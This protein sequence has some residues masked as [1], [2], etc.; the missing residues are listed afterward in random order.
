MKEIRLNSLHLENFMGIR[1]LEFSPM[2]KNAILRGDNGTFKTSTYSAFLWILFG[3]DSHGNATESFTIKTKKDG[4]VIHNIDHTVEAELLVDGVPLKLKRNYR[5]VWSKKRKVLKSHKTDYW[6]NDE[7]DVLKKDYDKRIAEIIPEETFRLLTDINYFNSDKFGWQKRRK[8]LF[9]LCEGLTE[10]ALEDAEK[11]KKILASKKKTINEKKDGIQ[12]RIDEK[13]RDLAAIADYNKAEIKA[14]ITDFEGQIQTIKSDSSR[15]ALLK[16]Q[17]EL[18]AKLSQIR[19][20]Q[21]KEKQKATKGIRVRIEKMEDDYSQAWRDL[22]G[23]EHELVDLLGITKNA[24]KKIESLYSEQDKLA[25]EKPDILDLCPTCSKPFLPEEKEAVQAEFNLQQSKKNEDIVTTG[26]K[27]RS[28]L[29]AATEEKIN[30]EV[31]LKAE[32]T[33]LAKIEKDLEKKKAEL[34]D[35]ISPPEISIGNTEI[36]TIGARLSEIDRKLEQKDQK[37]D[38]AT[39]EAELKTERTKIAKIDAGEDAKARIVELGE[40][41]KSLSAEIEK[42]EAD[43][44][45]AEEN[46][47]EQARLL[48]VPINAKFG[49]VKF[50]LFEKQMNEGVRPTCVTLIDGIPYGHGLNKGNEINAG[51]DIIHTLSQHYQIQCP[52]FIDN[53]ESISYPID[54][55]CQ[56]FKLIKVKDMK[57]LEITIEE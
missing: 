35:T 47:R 27:A 40:Q 56:C 23:T 31:K 54:P 41:E 49:L 15:F 9:Q 11:K 18:G 51:L 55:G 22:N 17:G 42:L 32:Q 6:I 20:G 2:G 21:E 13:E 19:A 14:R 45:K 7:P 43:L 34:E 44:F 39:L 57:K 38:R 3:K 5:E 37:Q 1:N 4:V 28:K 12:P 53:C 30:L 33:N 25:A 36:G 48:E 16:E 10:D 8:I 24:E 50:Q 46:I 29:T 26:K 52:V